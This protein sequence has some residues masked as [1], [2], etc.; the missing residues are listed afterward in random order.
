MKLRNTIILAVLL[1]VLLGYAYYVQARGGGSATAQATPSAT[2][3]AMFDFV[4]DNANKFQVTDVQTNQ[5]V[6]VTRQG[7]TWH[8]QQPKDSATDPLRIASALSDVAHLNATRVLTNA[9]DLSA[10]GLI[11]GT[12]EARVTM[13]DTTQ[14]VLKIGDDTVDHTASY[15]LKNDDKSKVYL[16]DPSTATTLRDF[17][18]NPPYP[19]TA[20]PTPLPTLTP[21]ATPTS[22]PTPGPGTPS[23]TPAPSPTP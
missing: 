16:I 12:I 14:Y 4:T 7:D 6:V 11:T 9:T 17:V 2:P 5:S 10:F 15:A 18:A 8:M 13:S 23:V 19:P 3:V 20:T 1:L 22:T 21:T